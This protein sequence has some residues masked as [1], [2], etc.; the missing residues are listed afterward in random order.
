MKPPAFVSNEVKKVIPSNETPLVNLTKLDFT[1]VSASEEVLSLT[2]VN[3]LFVAQASVKKI[4]LGVTKLEAATIKTRDE[5]LFLRGILG[6]GAATH[7]SRITIHGSNLQALT[8]NEIKGIKR[9]SAYEFNLNSPASYLE[10]RARNPVLINMISFDGLASEPPVS[11]V[12][13]K[14]VNM[15]LTKALGITEILPMP[16]LEMLETNL[17]I[18]H[19]EPLVG[20]YLLLIRGSPSYEVLLNLF[21]DNG[22]SHH[23]SSEYLEPLLIN[24]EKLQFLFSFSDFYGYPGGDLVLQISRGTLVSDPEI[25]HDE[26]NDA[27]KKMEPPLKGNL[28][29]FLEAIPKRAALYLKPTMVN[30]HPAVEIT[31][32]GILI[33][34]MKEAL[35][36]LTN[37]YETAGGGLAIFYE[38][39]SLV[40]PTILLDQIVNEAWWYLMSSDYGTTRYGLDNHY[41]MRYDRHLMTLHFLLY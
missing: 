41:V 30:V 12:S 6:L 21:L 10:L 33:N 22:Y 28:F 38:G 8:I 3:Q 24:Q 7:I 1:V 18:I 15:V 26:F 9:D 16:V 23:A 34:E 27:L 37:L 13:W 20:V 11:M 4:I 14:Y 2:E 5:A 19:E 31:A 40:A 29:Y 17:T 36:T 32:R 39:H 35:L 25:S